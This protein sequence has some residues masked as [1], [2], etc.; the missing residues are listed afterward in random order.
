MIPYFR[1]PTIDLRIVQIEP[2]GIMSALGVILAA[3]LV[4][5]AI[6]SEG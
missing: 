4:S 5:K 2:F 1:P 3:F 6:R